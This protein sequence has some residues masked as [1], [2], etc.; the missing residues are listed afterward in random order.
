MITII[1]INTYYYICITSIIEY[2]KI[3]N[4]ILFIFNNDYSLEQC[5]NSSTLIHLCYVIFRGQ[6]VYTSGHVYKCNHV[7]KGIHILKLIIFI[8][9]SI[10]IK[11]AC[12]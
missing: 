2:L 12:L 11:K 6:Q 9:V 8:K 3:I 4:I 5:Y 10:F 1:I 7:C